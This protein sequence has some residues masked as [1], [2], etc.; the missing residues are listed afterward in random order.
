MHKKGATSFE[1]MRNVNGVVHDSF[2]EACG[3]LGLLKDDN[4][5]H[6]A[7]SENAVHSMPRQLR[8][9]FV[10]ILS[11]NQVAD[12]S[13]LWD[14]HW[15]SLSEDILYNRSRVTNNLNLQLSQSDIKNLCL[16]C[17]ILLFVLMLA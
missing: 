3:A 6:V 12:P 10:H 13:K 5:W 14:Q 15:E 11:N 4:Q 16:K 17:I 1:E 2:K 7:L 8:E 9:L